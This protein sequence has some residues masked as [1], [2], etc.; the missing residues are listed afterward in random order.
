MYNTSMHIFDDKTLK[1]AFSK[2]PSVAPPDG[3]CERLAARI[4]RCRSIHATRNIIFS[5]VFLACSGLATFYASQL[6]FGDL[7][8]SGFVD[9]LSMLVPD[10]GELLSVWQSVTFVLLESFPFMSAL[11]VLVSL[12]L[13]L[14]SL[15]FFSYNMSAYR[16]GTARIHSYE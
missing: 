3:L 14:Q 11:A 15:R 7:I 2:L 9:F 5:S 10:T 4:E 13:F 8:R 6:V 12:T 16:H 1:S